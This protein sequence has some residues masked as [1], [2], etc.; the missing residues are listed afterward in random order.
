[1]ADHGMYLG[2]HNRTGK[3]NICEHDD[4]GSWPFYEALAHV[5]LLIYAPG[6]SGGARVDAL[7][8]PPD[9]MPTLLDLAGVGAPPGLHGHSLVPLLRGEGRDWPRHA[10]FSGTDLTRGEGKNGPKVTV[11]DG[12]WSLLLGADGHC[13]PELYHRPSDPGQGNNVI[14]AHPDMAVGLHGELMAFLRQVE[15]PA[16]ERMEGALA[17]TD[18]GARA[19][20]QEAPDYR[21]A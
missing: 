11:S 17:G 2:E 9:V 16:V 14:L 18:A 19:R 20:G 8:Q 3:S 12:E 5:P 6:V 15:S 1:M 10:A 21:S 4:R 7:A 13:A